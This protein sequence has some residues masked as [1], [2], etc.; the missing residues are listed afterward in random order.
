MIPCSVS[1]SYLNNEKKSSSGAYHHTDSWSV[2]HWLA[3]LTFLSWKK[4]VFIF[5]LSAFWVAFMTWILESSYRQL[6]EEAL[7]TL[8]CW[9]AKKPVLPGLRGLLQC[10]LLHWFYGWLCGANRNK[11][12]VILDNSFIH[13]SKKFKAKMKEWEEQE[14]LIFFLPPY[15]PELN[16]IEILSKKDQVSV[17][18][19]LYNT[20]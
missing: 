11:T 13:R 8:G 1:N 15:S 9:P 19:F 5:N 12:V 10:K 2:S 6:G 4:D 18:S 17:D 20:P 7:L 14:V 16:L 3:W